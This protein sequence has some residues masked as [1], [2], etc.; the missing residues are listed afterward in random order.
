[1]RN[2]IQSNFK[3]SLSQKESSEDE[4]HFVQNIIQKN[5]L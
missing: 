3:E 1:M 4:E 5:Y 2:I